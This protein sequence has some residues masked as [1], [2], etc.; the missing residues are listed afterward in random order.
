MKAGAITLISLL[1]TASLIT[2]VPE[3]SI[4]GDSEYGP[5]WGE[6]LSFD[7]GTDRSPVMRYNTQVTNSTSYTP[8]RGYGM[9]GPTEAFYVTRRMLGED[10][11]NVLQRSWVYD[12]YGDDRTVDGLRSKEQFSFRADLENGTYRLLLWI[13]DL[14]K[15]IYSMNVSVNG[16]W[17]LKGADAFH[18]VFR[19]MYFDLL[20][21]PRDPGK[22]YTNYGMAVPYYLEVNVTEGYLVVNVSGNDTSYRDLL[23]EELEKEPPHSYLTWMSTGNIKGSAGTGPWRYIGGPFTNASVL[24]LDIYPFPDFPIDGSIGSLSADPDIDASQVIYGIDAANSENLEGAFQ[25]WK[26]SMGNELSGR[27]RLARSQLGLILAGALDLDREIDI[28]PLVEPD[29]QG[30]TELRGDP[31]HLE[32]WTWANTANRGLHFEFNRTAYPGDDKVKNHFFEANKAFSLLNTIPEASPLHPKISLWAARCLMNLDPHRWTSASGTALEM[33]E[34]LRH[35]DPDNPYIRMYLDTTR[36]DPPTWEI[37]TSVI[38]TTGKYDSWTLRDYNAGH[39]DAPVWASIL[40]EE[41]G[42]LYDVTDWW[43]LNRMQENGYLGGGWTD[44]V[45]MIGLFGFDALISE[46]ADD[47]SLE[48][49][50][51]FVDGMLNSGQV[52]M[53]LGY[54]AAFADVEHTA[55][56][57]GDSLPMMIAVDFGNPRWVEFSMKTAVLMRDLWMGTNE[58]GWFQFRSNYLSATRVGTG[59]QAEDSWINFRAALP[60]LWYWWYSNDQEA[61]KLIVDWAS[62]WVNASL[63]TGKD[64]PIGVI[65]AG[66]GWPDGEIGGHDSPNWYTAAHPQGSVNYDW[67]PQKYKSYITTL[68]ESAYEATRNNTFLEPLRLEAEIAQDYIDD[69][70]PGAE[71]GTRKWAGKILGQNAVDSYQSTL[72]KYGLPGGS[73][74]SLLWNPT[75]AVDSCENGYH[76]IRK[77]YPLM[78]TEASATD[79]VLFV[80]V[81]NPFLIYT[82]GYIGGALLA[83]QFTYSGLQRDFAA[84]VRDANTRSANISIYGFF[85]GERQA[86]LIPWALETKGRYSITVGPDL[87]GNGVMDDIDEVIDFTYQGRGQKVPF[88]LTG[89]QEH[90]LSVERAEEGSGLRPLLPDPAFSEEEVM[91][92]KEN[93]TVTVSVHNIGS[94]DSKGLDIYLYEDLDGGLR[95][96]G[97][98]LNVSIPA[99]SGLEPS[100]E[101]IDLYVWKEPWIGEV[102]IRLDPDDELVEITDSNNELRGYWD[103]EGILVTEPDQP[104]QVNGTLPVLY[105]YED[106]PENNLL[107]L[108]DYFWD[109]D[110]RGLVFSLE[111]SL[112]S[113]PWL[114][115]MNGS[116]VSFFPSEPYGL[117]FNGRLV[118]EGI[119][120]GPG[121]D[122][123][124]DTRDDVSLDLKVVLE[125]LPVNDPPVLSGIEV[126]GLRIEITPEEMVTVELIEDRL[127]HMELIVTDVDNES[128]NITMEGLTEGFELLGSNLTYLG[129]EWDEPYRII[130]FVIDDGV[131]SVEYDIEFHLNRVIDPPGWIG[132]RFRN[133]SVV[134]PEGGTV[135]VNTYQ[136]EELHIELLVE[137]HQSIRVLRTGKGIILSN[138]TIRFTPTQEH[139]DS[140]PLEVVLRAEGEGS[141][142]S[143]LTV[144]FSIRDVNDAPS[145]PGVPE[146]NG[147]L[148]VGEKIKMSSKGSIDIDGDKLEYRWDFGDGNTTDWNSMLIVEHSYSFKGTFDIVLMVKDGRGGEN[149]SSVSLSIDEKMVPEEPEPEDGKEK[150][151]ISP[152]WAILPVLLIIALIIVLI[153]LFYLTRKRK[154]AEEEKGETK[155]EGALE[156]AIKGDPTMLEE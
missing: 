97:G 26:L 8:E 135:I 111:P 137:Y 56:L 25:H 12:E 50:S 77:C 21:D 17:V 109:P 52:D 110:G 150:D 7:F 6:S 102:V 139:V 9:L 16:E 55:E 146:M 93:G 18:N 141:L 11:P 85:E 118:F 62:S 35:L 23:E 59:G 29:L 47:L 143:D 105:A 81:P 60:A 138:G 22:V 1:L 20:P 154:D 125:V 14:E 134:R 98:A 79:R 152:L 28:L 66:L 37:P 148:V 24:G 91:I 132:I 31:A 68:L 140:S 45:E 115:E 2:F 120:S 121:R 107:D 124:W 10:P 73:P 100:I 48:G 74:S 42:W 103:L 122:G 123:I 151:G 108:S 5:A 76:Y 112:H 116:R 88:N 72:D 63:S 126:E 119:G 95:H 49:A 78:T 99:P 41:L 147:T 4:S 90:I 3:G 96:I 84:M 32:L 145:A 86:A 80:G 69:P 104:V 142:F 19:S 153:P 64:K 46:G 44:D 83:P 136:G 38:S 89:G 13:G 114:S 133:G 40:H 117:N 70:S 127:T 53:E 87:D 82:G 155:P 128:V 15:G 156:A 34:N 57:T 75:S 43:V 92:D 30:N 71:P 113:S 61:K 106:E 94:M 54:S 65:P 149:R 51:R 39:G 33:M 58:R 67:A 131:D 130:G 144:I 101:K 36:E 129:S 27:N